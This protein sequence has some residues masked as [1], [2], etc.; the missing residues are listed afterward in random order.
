MW[1]QCDDATDVMMRLILY[2]LIHY[3]IIN[4]FGLEQPMIGD[5]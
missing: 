3:K 4:F 2:K 5:D 1:D